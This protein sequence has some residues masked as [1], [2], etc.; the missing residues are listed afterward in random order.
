MGR[1]IC[2]FESHIKLFYLLFDEHF[3]RSFKKVESVLVS[4]DMPSFENS[5]DS[6]QLA[7]MKP[8]DQDL[9]CFPCCL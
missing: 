1:Y 2:F 3:L 5:V 7:S 6:D 4:L 9:H 8:A